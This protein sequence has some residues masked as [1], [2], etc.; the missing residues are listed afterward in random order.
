MTRSA[1]WE[2]YEDLAIGIT[3]VMAVYKI[4]ISW[5]EV[6]PACELLMHLR[7]DFPSWVTGDRRGFGVVCEHVGYPW[8]H[9]PDTSRC[10]E[11]LEGV[12]IKE[13]T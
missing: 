3:N 8:P 6:C 13:A 12:D 9:F 5:T 7:M 4:P 2:F 11:T 1:S 10:L